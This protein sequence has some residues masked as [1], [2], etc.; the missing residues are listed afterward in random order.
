MLLI[1]L[2]YKLN[3]INISENENNLIL[4]STI[5]FFCLNRMITF[6]LL[7]EIDVTCLLFKIDNYGQ[8]DSLLTSGAI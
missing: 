8:N 4:P 1:L 6:C 7:F 2:L 3:S 5:V